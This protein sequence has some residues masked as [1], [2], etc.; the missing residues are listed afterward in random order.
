MSALWTLGAVG[1]YVDGL[2]RN[3]ENILAEID[4]IAATSTTLHYY[5]S[6]SAR[7]SIKGHFWGRTNESTLQGY[8]L[9]SSNRTF[10]GPFSFSV[11]L[12]IKTIKTRRVPDKTGEATAATGE[13]FACE[14]EGIAQ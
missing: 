4:I 11:S 8:A 13:F 14:I 1:I 3:G 5:G 2:E 10:S 12:A 9:S 7:W 6:K